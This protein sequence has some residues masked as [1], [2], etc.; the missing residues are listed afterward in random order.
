MVGRVY[1]RDEEGAEI[2]HRVGLRAW[3]VVG[4]LLLRASFPE[5]APR[6]EPF[7]RRAQGCATRTSR[8]A[9][10]N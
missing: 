3:G 8:G 6:V 7:G 1:R 9:T 5:P 4:A 2:E 10:R